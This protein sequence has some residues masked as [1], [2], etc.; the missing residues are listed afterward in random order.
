ML[1]FQNFNDFCLTN[2]LNICLWYSQICRFGR[3]V[4]ADERLS[5]FFDLSRDVAM[6][7]NSLVVATQ[8]FSS[9][10]ISETARHRHRVT[11]EGE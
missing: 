10:H 9:R 2:Y 1:L 7:M 4:T 3:T 6:T 11:M 5:Y 8:F